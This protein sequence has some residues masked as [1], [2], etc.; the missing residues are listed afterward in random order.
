M[1]VQRVG[2]AVV[3]IL[4]VA[5]VGAV[6]CSSPAAS[7]DLVTVNGAE[8]QN[9]LIPTAVNDNFGSRVVE[10]LFAGLKY[11]DAEG[12]AH[13]EVAESIETSDRRHY[14]I[15][16]KDWKFTDGSAVTAKSF[17]DA[18]NFGAL[19]SNAQVQN[20][21]FT[22]IAGYD[23]VAAKPPRAQTM[24]GLKVVD[25]RTF[26]VELKRPSIDF[27]LGLGHASFYPL[28]EVAFR[29]MKAFGERPVGNGPYRFEE[30]RHN[31]AIEVRANPDYRGG[32]PARNKGLRF[33]M[34]QSFDTAYADLQA[35]NLDALDRIPDS[36]LSTY[37][38]DLG[39][40]AMT[41]PM[42]QNDLIGIQNNVPHFTGAEGILRRKAL[43]MAINREQLCDNIFRGARIPAKGFTVATLPGFDPAT[44][45]SE[46]LRYEPGE[47]KKLWQQANSIAP[48]SGRL[49][50]AYNADGN[51]QS[52]IDA[53][54]NSIK[55]TLGID[56]ISVPYPTFSNFRAA[57]TGRTI[58]KAYRHG[59]QG[60]YP[61][62]LEVLTANYYSTSGS[63]DI[64]YGNPEFDRL[65]DAAQAAPT[66]GE[67]H[68]LV[69]RA[70]AVLFRD[71][72]D[73]PVLDFVAAAGRAP[74]V[75]QAPLTWSGLFDFEN[76]VK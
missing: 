73:I 48:W 70:Q 40:R 32:R 67:S 64:G 7:D 29:D 6:G 31:V 74:A 35:G 75:R 26:T 37:R 13:N 11:Y 51:H 72:A 55:N 45:G 22:P 41:K 65:I 21:I 12:N 53:V 54:V 47:A 4:V 3:A 15:T 25:D 43:S 27:E 62:M 58:G 38:A 49:E 63:N 68:E 30:W 46:V 52:W 28:P 33:V 44:P 59:W 16:I 56:A 36:A 60:H 18:W 19:G 20:W 5:G 71:M 2:A 8:P 17:V 76:I 34:Y 57:I 50:L 61:S 66:P 23:E 1:G 14:R 39:D 24:S 10:R 9:P 42:S 69:A